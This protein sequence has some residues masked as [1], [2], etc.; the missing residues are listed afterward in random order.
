MTAPKNRDRVRVLHVLEA[1]F[2]GTARHLCDLVTVTRDIDHTVV[3]PSERFGSRTDTNAIARLEQAGAQVHVMDMRRAPQHPDNFVALTRLGRLIRQTRPD[4]VHGHSSIGG[5]LARAAALAAPGTPAVWTPNGLLLSRPIVATEKLLARVTAT[6]IAVSAS[7]AEV[8]HAHKLGKEIVVIPNGI[9]LEGTPE[10]LPLR[11]TL[12]I[13]AGAPVVGTVARLVPQKAP[14]DFVLCCREIHEARPDTHFVIVG[15]G[16]LNESMQAALADWDHGGHFHHV[17]YLDDASLAMASFDVFVLLSRY[18]G[19]PYAPL[20]A[21]RFGVPVVLTD[22]VGNRD[23]VE[24]G[25][26][27]Y[28]VAPKDYSTAARRTLE[29]LDSPADR[30]AM[31][32]AA[33]KRLYSVFDRELMGEATSALYHRLAGREK[34]RVSPATSLEAEIRELEN[35]PPLM[36]PVLLEP[37]EAVDEV[38]EDAAI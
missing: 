1:I 2:G 29:L 24:D 5:A 28:L 37:A 26:T 3:I 21:M 22:V 18:E 6:T 7:E 31:S 20:E 32:K 14:V 30:A 34:V 11:E 13:P 12:G 15:D 8:M 35:A 17:P 36:L 33:Y 9:D 10:P 16:P 27:G 4:I 19:A 25:I 23:A 38:K